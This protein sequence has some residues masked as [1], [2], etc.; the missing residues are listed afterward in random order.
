MAITRSIGRPLLSVRSSSP[1]AAACGRISCFGYHLNGSDTRSASKPRA[2][3]SSTSCLTSSSAP[4]LTRGTWVSQTSTVRTVIANRARYVACRKLMTSP[5]CTT[6]SLPS[7]R[8][9]P[10]SLHAAIDPRVTSAS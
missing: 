9:S 6:Y 4:P 1:Q 8:T 2:R 10:A 3:S 7:S 5:S